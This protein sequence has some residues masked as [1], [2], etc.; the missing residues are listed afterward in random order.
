M[1]TKLTA[2]EFR[3]MTQEEQLKMIKELDQKPQE[4]LEDE[5]LIR[6]FSGTAKNGD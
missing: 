2:K 6:L 1:K 5:A 4:C 3:E